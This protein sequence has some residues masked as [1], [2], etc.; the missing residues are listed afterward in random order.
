MALSG[1]AHTTIYLRILKNGLSRLA[2]AGRLKSSWEVV[3]TFSDPDNLETTFSVQP[4]CLQDRA[5]P[6]EALQ[7]DVGEVARSLDSIMTEG[8]DALRG[9]YRGK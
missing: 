7:A 5:I 6:L 2:L 4:S 9:H 1:K 8:A 3:V